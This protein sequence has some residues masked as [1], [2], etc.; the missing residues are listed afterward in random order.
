MK[1]DLNE[2][3]RLESDGTPAYTKQEILDGIIVMNNQDQGYWSSSIRKDYP[4]PLLVKL[5]QQL[6]RHKEDI[7]II[8]EVWNSFT[9]ENREINII[10][11]GMI[12]RLY[13]IPI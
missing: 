6:W 4:N 5:C 12:P 11:S 7:I 10:K 2:L 13:H 8:A 3:Y 1:Q 9:Q